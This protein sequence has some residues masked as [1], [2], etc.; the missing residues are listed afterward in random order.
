MNPWLVEFSVNTIAGIVGVFVGVWL[1]LVTDRRREARE[2]SQRK[3]ERAEQ[4]KRARHTV[5]GSVVKN[6]SEASRLRD[7]VDERKPIEIIHTNLEVAVWNAV[8][9][10]VMRKAS[11][12]EKSPL[13]SKFYVTD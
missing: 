10:R 9:R 6:A 1:A 12:Q 7:R 5:L 2:E 11:T 3:Q 13:D 4:F 8:R